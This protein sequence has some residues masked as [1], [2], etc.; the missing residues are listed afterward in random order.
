MITR[1]FL[2]LAAF[3]GLVYL[4][5]CD[6]PGPDEPDDDPIDKFV[7]PTTAAEFAKMLGGDSKDSVV[8]TGLH[9][10][11][12]AW[13]PRKLDY[14]DEEKEITNDPGIKFTE[15]WIYFKSD[16]YQ[17]DRLGYPVGNGKW[18]DPLGKTGFYYEMDNGVLDQVFINRF[19]DYPPGGGRQ[20]W[21]GAKMT[22]TTFEYQRD[23]VSGKTKVRERFVWQRK[24]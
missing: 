12:R 5:A 20:D 22:K 15:H 8:W 24:P 18:I 13:D 21:F 1:K 6:K 2:F 14:S 10:Y 4:A 16:K 9:W 11:Q 23:W 3:T 7:A 19:E 17:S